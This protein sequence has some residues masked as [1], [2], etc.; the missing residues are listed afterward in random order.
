MPKMSSFL[1]LPPIAISVS[2]MSRHLSRAL[3]EIMEWARLL[4]H[5]YPKISILLLNVH[6]EAFRAVL[7]RPTEVICSPTISQI[8]QSWGT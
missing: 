5:I 7:E 3:L 2:I 1:P 6:A 4:K 8:F